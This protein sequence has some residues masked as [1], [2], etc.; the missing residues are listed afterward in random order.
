MTQELIINSVIANINDSRWIHFNELAYKISCTSKGEKK[1]WLMQ[2]KFYLDYGIVP[3][4]PL[5]VLYLNLINIS[6]YHKT[7]SPRL[8]SKY[9]N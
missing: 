1:N 7:I 2:N 5:L 9:F 8:L 4:Q 6:Y 3:L